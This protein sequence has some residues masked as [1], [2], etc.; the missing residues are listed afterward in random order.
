MTKFFTPILIV[1]IWLVVS[2]WL[3]GFFQYNIATWNAVIIGIILIVFSFSR[4]ITK[5]GNK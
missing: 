2:P 5:T 4:K 1:G 3:L